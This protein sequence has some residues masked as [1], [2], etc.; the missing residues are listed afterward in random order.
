MN[1]VRD[2]QRGSVSNEN[3]IL[4]DPDVVTDPMSQVDLFFIL[5][6]PLPRNCVYSLNSLLTLPK[7]WRSQIVWLRGKVVLGLFWKL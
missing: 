2:E 5:H 7:L 1:E 3:N 6:C 4:L